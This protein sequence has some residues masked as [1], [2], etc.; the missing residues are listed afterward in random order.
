MIDSL[1]YIKAK[2]PEVYS[3]TKYKIIEISA[4]LAARQRKRAKL[5]GVENHVEIVQSDFFK[6]DGGGPEPCYVV[7][8]EVLVSYWNFLVVEDSSPGQFRT[9]HDPVRY[10]YTRPNA[11]GCR[12]RRSGRVHL[13][14]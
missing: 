11:S 8:L 14:I 12:Y 2:Y 5:A 9:R 7:A 10:R 6:W 3:R 4:P 1:R 13:A